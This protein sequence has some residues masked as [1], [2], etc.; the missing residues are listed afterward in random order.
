M[1]PEPWK[2]TTENVNYVT[3]PDQPIN[4]N[5]N[6]S[7]ME[8]PTHICIQSQPGSHTHRQ[9]SQK[10]HQERGEGGDGCCGGDEVAVDFCYALEV[11]WVCVAYWVIGRGTDAGSSGLR[12][13]GCVDGDLM[14]LIV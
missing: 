4:Q 7:L 1:I 10:A 8:M 14:G 5:Q 2:P 12:Y 6:Q 13:D 3:N 11:V 9:V